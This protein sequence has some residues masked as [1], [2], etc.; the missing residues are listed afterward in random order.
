MAELPI[1][2]PIDSPR[3]GKDVAQDDPRRKV[4]DFLELSRHRWLTSSQASHTMRE[5]MRYDQKFRSGGKHQWEDIDASVRTAENRPCLTVNRIPQ[6]IRQVSNQARS[7]RSQLQVNPRGKGATVETAAAIQGLMRSVEIDSDAEI[8]YDTATDHQLTIGIGFCRL[9]AEYD[10]QTGFTQVCRI[11]RIRNPLSCYWDPSFQEYE[12]EDWRYFHIIGVLGKDEYEA[13]WGNYSSYQ[14]L[15]EYIKTTSTAADWMPEGKVVLAEYFYVTIEDKVLLELEDG[16]TLFE[17]AQLAKFAQ[18]W[19]D[20]YQGQYPLPQIT[21]TRTVQ[22]K[23]VRWALHNAVAILEGN[24]DRTEGKVIPGTRIPIFPCIGDEQDLDGQ[25]DY[26]GMVRDAI[27]PAQMYN[28][29]TSSIAETVALAPK[30]PWVAAAGQIEEYLDDWKEANTKPFS[31]L[32]Y[33]PTTVDG[34]I[35]PPPQRSVAN[36]PIEALVMGL[37]EADQD[38][39]A[40]M[41]LFEASLGEKGPQQSGKA[42]T[43][44]QQQGVQ[45]NSNFLDNRERMKRAIGRSLLEWMPIIYDEARLEHLV[46][47]DGKR[48]QAMIH[49][50][51]QFAPN[52]DEIPPDVTKVFDIGV[53]VFELTINTGPSWQ[54]EK[55]ETEAWLLDLFKVLPGLAAIGA[56]I[57]LE[58]SDN[59]AAKQLA[60]RAKMMLPPQL[61]DKNDPATALPQLQAQN[62]Q[63]QQLLQKAHAAITSM[64]Q[65]IQSRLQGKL[66]DA[67]AKILA[68]IIAEK[69][70][71]DA[72]A[73]KAGMEGH[74]TVFEAERERMSQVFEHLSAMAQQDSQHDQT[75]E[76]Q[77]QAAALAPPP[78]EEGQA[79]ATGGGQ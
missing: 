45:A 71:I 66:V 27:G 41:G 76:Q 4:Q 36:P 51:A 77:A 58:N 3:R 46:A 15:T 12:G 35:V 54:T 37:K 8:A 63:L 72:A 65:E 74:G 24:K 16:T 62:A 38:I 25:V 31:V 68:A 32:R 57:V 67:H 20:E 33:D 40:V 30:S 49:A 19:Q 64:A 78:P 10:A 59:P 39:K 23:V 73:I 53:G 52:P 42:I 50:G 29:W 14:S 17:G 18:A 26:R 28:F 43:A 21:R 75:L 5:L 6:F 1:G 70:N 11:K 13:R 2:G 44:V 61:Q 60:Q 55:Q 69:G 56:D 22:T 47:P 34:Q 9:K 79:G 48:Y 7:N